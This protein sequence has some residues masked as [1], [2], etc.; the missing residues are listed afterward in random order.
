MTK[1]WEWN[2]CLACVSSENFEVI[3]S[4]NGL[5]SLNWSISNQ[6]VIWAVFSSKLK[7]DKPYDLHCLLRRHFI[8]KLLVV[9]Q[10]VGCFLHLLFVSYC[11]SD[12][13]GLGEAKKLLEEAVVLPLL[14]PDYFTGIRRPWKVRFVAGFF[15]HPRK[16]KVAI[17][18]KN[19]KF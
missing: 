6:Y 9:C 7:T 18:S 12:I 2:K 4:T 14:M 3:T 5:T 19:V 10:N 16:Y 17:N 8:G 1:F 15:C 13:A 11:R